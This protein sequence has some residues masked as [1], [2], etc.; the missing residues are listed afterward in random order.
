MVDAV[1]DVL[2]I[3]RM[4]ILPAPDFGARVEAG[5]IGGIARS[6]DKLVIL[7]D[8]DRVLGAETAKLAS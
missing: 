6:G 2:D 3:P 5:Y 8:I 1:S 4:D 7:L